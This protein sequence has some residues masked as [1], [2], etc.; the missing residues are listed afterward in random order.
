MSK[1]KPTPA[2]WELRGWSIKHPGNGF[3]ICV[4]DQPDKALKQFGDYEEMLDECK[5]NAEL[6]AM[7]PML[8]HANVQQAEEIKALRSQVAD[9]TDMMQK[10]VGLHMDAAAQRDRAVGH[11]CDVLKADDGQAWKEARRFLDGIGAPLARKP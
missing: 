4:V 11:L 7:A 8:A 3:R 5:A 2:P 9:M 6:I 1:A 10:A